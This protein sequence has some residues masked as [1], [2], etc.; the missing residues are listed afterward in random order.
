MLTKWKADLAKRLAIFVDSRIKPQPP[1]EGF[2]MLEGLVW[3][4]ENEKNSEYQDNIAEIQKQF[5]RLKHPFIAKYITV[6]RIAQFFNFSDYFYG[7]DAY[8]ENFLDQ[9]YTLSHDKTYRYKVLYGL[10]SMRRSIL[11]SDI[12]KNRRVD[13][14]NTWIRWIIFYDE[15]D[16]IIDWYDV[17]RWLSW[18]FFV[19]FM[20]L[21]ITQSYLLL[22]PIGVAR[23]GIGSLCGWFIG[24]FFR[25]DEMGDIVVGLIL[26]ILFI[27]V[28]V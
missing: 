18:G 5:G 7:V 10:Q 19:G 8:G 15:V 20:T 16:P 2:K 27:S 14:V 22:G 13:W 4:F 3:I 1:T 26:A 9:V 24:A 6:D 12:T 28:I 11:R 21:A 25:N 23:V 17:K